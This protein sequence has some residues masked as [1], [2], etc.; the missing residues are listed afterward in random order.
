MLLTVSQVLD[1]FSN[2]Y[3]SNFFASQPQRYPHS[4]QYPNHQSNI[5]YTHIHPHPLE[6]NN[7]TSTATTT[8]HYGGL[9]NA[10]MHV[11]CDTC[12]NKHVAGNPVADKQVLWQKEIKIAKTTTKPQP[13]LVADKHS[14]E[15]KTATTSCH[16][17]QKTKARSSLQATNNHVQR[18]QAQPQEVCLFSNTPDLSWPQ[19]KSKQKNYSHILLSLSHYQLPTLQEEFIFRHNI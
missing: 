15:K 3:I 13:S 11:S 16:N 5:K 14:A 19:K 6:H 4:P 8:N 2:L 1:L 7:H 17:M 12:K 10:I 9:N 18:I